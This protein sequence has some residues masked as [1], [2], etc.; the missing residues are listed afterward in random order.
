MECVRIRRRE[1]VPEAFAQANSC[2]DIPCNAGKFSCVKERVPCDAGDS[3][4]VE[5]RLICFAG[6][7]R[8]LSKRIEINPDNIAQN[9]NNMNSNLTPE[10]VLAESD[11]A[12]RVWKA[13]AEL[14]L[15]DVTFQTYDTTRSGL[16]AA[17]TQVAELEN[18]L[19]TAANDRDK[20]MNDLNSMT[21]RLR[22]A[23]RG[24][25]GP[26]STEY[27]ELGG[28]RSSDR[29]KPVRKPVAAEAK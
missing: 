29:K 26:D 18:Q 2:G 6:M 5:G 15:K 23:A 10:K 8:E 4:R 27:E 13:N 14:K 16:Q 24:Y 22:T 7:M 28:T 11:A 19:K 20:L 12:I 1:H 21:I 9:K 17:Q 3:A 25:F